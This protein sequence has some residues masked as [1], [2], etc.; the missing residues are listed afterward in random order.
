MRSDEF[1]RQALDHAAGRIAT[2]S[3]RQLQKS[4]GCFKSAYT[5]LTFGERNT[6]QQVEEWYSALPKLPC[7]CLAS[8]KSSAWS[9]YCTSTSGRLLQCIPSMADLLGH[10]DP[11]ISKITAGYGRELKLTS[12]S[13]M[14]SSGL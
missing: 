6:Q 1:L 13:V 12:A 14:S 7:K 5:E 11:R 9:R 4:A 3:L 8:P 2:R 10:A